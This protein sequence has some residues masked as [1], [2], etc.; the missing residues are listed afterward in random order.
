MTVEQKIQVIHALSAALA[1]NK[2]TET[3]A[4]IIS[5]KLI[6]IVKSITSSD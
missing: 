6:E 4:S 2:I 3:T 5:A 1:S